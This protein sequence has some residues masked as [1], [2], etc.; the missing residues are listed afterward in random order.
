MHDSFFFGGG[1]GVQGHV[2]GEIG[3]RF[4]LWVATVGC[5]MAGFAMPSQR[6]WQGRYGRAEA[7]GLRWPHRRKTV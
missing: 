5:I 4:T 7:S 3:G 2:S 6:R 1:G